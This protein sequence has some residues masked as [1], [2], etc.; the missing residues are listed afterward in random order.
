M[1]VHERACAKVGC[2]LDK[3][4]GFP[5]MTCTLYGTTCD[6]YDACNWATFQTSMFDRPAAG[7][8]STFSK[9]IRFQ[10]SLKRTHCN[11]WRHR[12]EHE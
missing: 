11:H 2:L 10:W 4:H 12:K 5:V 9:W 3:H 8:Q 1:S 7:L 6:D